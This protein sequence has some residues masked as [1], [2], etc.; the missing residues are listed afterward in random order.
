D[1]PHNPNSPPKLVTW[2][3]QTTD[4]MCLLSVQLTTDTPADLRKVVAMRGA[5]LGG[6]LAG[7]VEEDDLPGN[8]G[9]DRSAKI[10][11]FVDALLD[12]GFMIPEQ[13]KDRMKLF[14]LDGD[15]RMSREEFEKIP[16]QIQDRVREE[17]RR[18]IREAQGSAG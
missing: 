8:K 7:G 5:R 15:G 1:N 11:M 3:E 2:G 12:K 10:E 18:R 4:E 6:A 17:I 9:L 13:H 14:D 16:A